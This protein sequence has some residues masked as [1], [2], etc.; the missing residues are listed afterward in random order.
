MEDS[1]TCGQDGQTGREEAGR[2]IG[3][4]LCQAECTQRT[5]EKQWRV[6]VGG[7]GVVF[8]SGSFFPFG[9]EVECVQSRFGSTRNPP[10]WPKKVLLLQ[11]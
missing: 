5:M 2:Q 3:T 7:G 6:L 4:G 9:P 11:I 10:P 1:R 8:P